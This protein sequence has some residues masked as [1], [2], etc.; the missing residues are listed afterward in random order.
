MPFLAIPLPTET[1]LRLAVARL[2]QENCDLR[3]RLLHQQR[4]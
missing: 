4:L 1:L 2:E 3:A